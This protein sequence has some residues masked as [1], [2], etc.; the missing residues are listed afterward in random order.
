MVVIPAGEFL[1]GSPKSEAG[2]RDDE[3]PQHQ[4]R[5]GKAFALGRK[6]LTV[7]EFGR[8]VQASGYRTSAEK[9]AGK[10]CGPGT[11]VTGSGTGGPG[12]S[13]ANRA[14]RRASSSRSPA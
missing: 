6:E 9:D 14:M 10:G 12:G 1:M 11:R 13:G 5:I 7:G 4:V 8:F 3:G 2:R